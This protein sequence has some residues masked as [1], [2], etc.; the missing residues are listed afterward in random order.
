MSVEESRLVVKC[1]VKEIQRGRNRLFIVNPGNRRQVIIHGGLK[2]RFR[3]HHIY[4]LY[5]MCSKQFI[6]GH[7]IINEGL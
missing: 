4:K 2:A 1:F 7:S 6:V 5:F 3:H